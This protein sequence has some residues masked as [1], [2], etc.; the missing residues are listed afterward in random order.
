[1]SPSRTYIRNNRIAFAKRK[2]LGLNIEIGTFL[3]ILQLF[4]STRAEQI[5]L[6]LVK[7]ATK[8]FVGNPMKLS[9]FL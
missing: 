7:H 8:D 5:Y 6:R 4:H 9:E 2:R 3:T 1:M